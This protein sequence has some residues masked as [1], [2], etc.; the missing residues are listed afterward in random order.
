[1]LNELIIPQ[2]AIDKIPKPDKPGVYK[3]GIVDGKLA[4]IGLECESGVAQ[5]KKQGVVE[6]H[7]NARPYQG[8]N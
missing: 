8:V 5:V 1:M 2:S 3:L 4:Y 6:F 7:P